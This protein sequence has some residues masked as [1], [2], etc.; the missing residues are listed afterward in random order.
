VTDLDRSLHE[1][2]AALRQRSVQ[3]A[4]VGG[5]AVAVRAEPRL[6]RDA[7]FAVAVASDAEAEALI[8]DLR[9]DDYEPFAAIE[10]T[11]A[12]RLATI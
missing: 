2:F 8:M 1:I 3:F 9:A 12:D 11:H 5:L 4:L 10:H 7:D 6:T